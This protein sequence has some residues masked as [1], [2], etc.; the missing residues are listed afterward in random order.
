MTAAV[1]L[2][3]IEPNCLLHL[4]DHTVDQ[5]EERQVRQVKL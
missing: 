2:R 4:Q 5:S 3:A 1:E